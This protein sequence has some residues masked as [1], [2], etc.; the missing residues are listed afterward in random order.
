MKNWDDTDRWCLQLQETQG[1]G[2]VLIRLAFLT[3]LSTERSVGSRF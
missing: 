3:T 2:A 1:C